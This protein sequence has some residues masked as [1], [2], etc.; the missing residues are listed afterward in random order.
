MAQISI[1]Q[2]N[3]L[4]GSDLLAIHQPLVFIVSLVFSPLPL[5]LSVTLFEGA[6][7]S[8]S[9]L[10]NF[11]ARAYKD[12][13]SDERYF[14]FD[15]GDLLKGYMHEYMDEAQ[16]S[17]TLQ[18]IDNITKQFTI[19]F[20]SIGVE[21]N[22]ITFNACHAVRQFGNKNGASLL[23]VNETQ[24]YYCGVGG[25]VYAYCYNDD[26]DAEITVNNT[27]PEDVYALDD[28][29]DMFTDDNNDLFLIQA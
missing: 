3:K 1:I 27:V 17:N 18:R 4:I 28:N 9:V 23:E 21:S 2:D 26:A 5:Y 14:A 24:T 12:V 25:T 11:V 19:E 7:N 16:S 22:T 13:S 29:L 10:G 15:A 20:S 6:D 8:G